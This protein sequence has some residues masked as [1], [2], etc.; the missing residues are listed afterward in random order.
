SHSSYLSIV[1]SILVY[2]YFSLT[3]IFMLFLFSFLFFFSCIAHLRYLHSFP[4]RRSS[5]LFFIL[6]YKLRSI[7]CSEKSG[8]PMNQLRFVFSVKKEQNQ[9]E[10]RA[11]KKVALPLL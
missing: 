9:Q 7:V 8:V 1:S 10:L 2:V 11:Q 3:S 4:T 6:L 5:D